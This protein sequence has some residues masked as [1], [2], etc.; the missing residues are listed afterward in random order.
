MDLVAWPH[1]LPSQSPSLLRVI[2]YTVAYQAL[3]MGIQLTYWA[4]GDGRAPV[5]PGGWT[6]TAEWMR[7][8]IQL[9][10]ALLLQDFYLYW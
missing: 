7:C 1:A 2:S 8:A 5:V 3:M 9:V 6:N 10:P 4:A